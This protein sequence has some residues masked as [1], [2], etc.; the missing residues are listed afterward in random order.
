MK[1]TLSPL[2]RYRQDLESD[3][4]AADEGQARGVEALEQIYHALLTEPAPAQERGVLAWLKSRTKPQV[5]ELT[6]VRG[7]YLWGGVGRG[8]THIVNSFH[9]A[10]PF[11]NKMRVHF[12]RFMQRVHAEL[13]TLSGQSDPLQVVADRLAG[14]ARV[15]T[16]DEFHVSDITD[17]MLLGKLLEYLFARGVTLVTTSNIK[18]DGLYAGGLQRQRFLP[19]IELIKRHTQVLEL[20]TGQDHRLRA[21]EQAEIYHSPLDDSATA[22][23]QRSF[24]AIADEPGREGELLEVLGRPIATV[25]MADGVAWF[26]F[27]A[28]CDGPRG[29]ADYIEVA[30]EFHTVLVSNVPSLGTTDNDRAIRFIMMVD[31]FYDRSVNLVVSAEALPQA[32]YGGERHAFAFERTVSRLIEMQSRDYLHKPHLP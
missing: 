23:L 9:D 16:F 11:D 6:P 18:P 28:L 19:A 4:F 22:S 30:R 3:D 1:H 20:G 24:R 29:A 32:L 13:K 14:E 17:A 5:P 10:L 26:D 27:D 12:H 25:R 21:L 7:L 15:L 31:E 8:K 2:A